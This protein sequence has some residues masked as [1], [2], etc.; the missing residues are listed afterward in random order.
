MTALAYLDVIVS[1][2][3]QGEK[4]REV[5]G[6]M[7][8]GN[9]KKKEGRLSP[10]DLATIN[11]YSYDK[12]RGPMVEISTTAGRGPKDLIEM[13][14]FY[15]LASLLEIEKEALFSYHIDITIVEGGVFN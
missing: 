3:R 1:L 15:D 9:A 5:S 4:E 6:R 14:R 10:D 8:L 11:F 7:V 2:R 12:D 13:P